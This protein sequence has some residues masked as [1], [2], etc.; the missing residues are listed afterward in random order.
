MEWRCTAYGRLHGMASEK[1]L[2]FS[3]VV[4]SSSRSNCFT[5]SGTPSYSLHEMP[6]NANVCDASLQV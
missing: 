4:E 3:A 2:G 5:H 6:F 1:L